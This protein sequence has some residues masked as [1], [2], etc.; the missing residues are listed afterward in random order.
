MLH[1]LLMAGAFCAALAGGAAS[2]SPG[3]SGA[4]TGGSLEDTNWSL[5]GITA[6]GASTPI[7]SAGAINL[8]FV[9]GEAGGSTGCNQY[10]APY[11][12]TGATVTF[13][14]V[15]ATRMACDESGAALETAYLAA[16]SVSSGFEAS[17]KTL[18]LTDAA[19]APLLTFGAAPMPSVEGTWAV[20]RFDDGS[21]L[22]TLSSDSALTLAFRSDGRTQGYGGC[23]QFSGPYGVS[24]N[25]I[26]IGPLLS[27]LQ[28]C[29]E[30]VDVQEQAYLAALQQAITW[31]ISS[32]SLELRD[33]EGALLVEADRVATR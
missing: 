13:G 4:G 25:E 28:T 22:A 23:N 16:L 24:G 6:G 29:G 7:A 19:G 9:A 10:S 15:I 14:P 11:A 33:S 2:R 30:I 12:V 20:T 1:A 26:A 18:T 3:A 8:D 31:S 5:T 17:G 21:T 32:D 27:T